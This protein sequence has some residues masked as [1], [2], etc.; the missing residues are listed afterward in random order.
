[1]LGSSL[2]SIPRYLDATEAKR[3]LRFGIIADVHKDI[4]HDADRRLEIFVNAMIAARADFIIQLGDFCIPKPEN[5]AFL[6]IFRR[7]DL[8]PRYHVLG[9]HD[10][11]GGYRREQAVAYY[12]MPHR[13]YAFEHAGIHFV[14]LDGNDR[15]PNHKSG[16]PRY[17]A[18]DQL[19]WLR[20]E[21]TQ[22]D[23]PVILFCHQSLENEHGIVNGAEVRNVLE[24]ANRLSGRRKVL[25]SF[26][27]HHHRDY[28]R[29]INNIV[30]PQINSAA[31]FWVGGNFQHVRYSAEIDKAFPYIK[32]TVPYREPIFAIVEIDLNKGFLR[33]KGRE[34]EFV[35][36]APW[37]LGESKDYWQATTLSAAVSNWKMPVNR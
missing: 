27:G 26:S 29:Q 21:L 35:G 22:S 9:N 13:Y 5:R 19:A 12:D 25:A 6:D 4:I 34:S 8:G 37:D 18:P 20:T 2:F 24:E 30:Y 10:M 28:V 11:D 23:K 32:Y 31:Y 3:P 36:P 15:P 1:M 17:I 16:Y 7:Y 33:I 14:V